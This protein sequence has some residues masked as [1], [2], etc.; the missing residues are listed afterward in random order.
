[1]ATN[2]DD[3]P[4]PVAKPTPLFVVLKPITYRGEV[5]ETTVDAL[6]SGARLTAGQIAAASKLSKPELVTWYKA[7][8]DHVTHPTLPPVLLP[9]EHLAE[10]ARALLIKRGVIAAA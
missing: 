4:K 6:V 8:S 7:N 3:K 9:F 1:M 10:S 2:I 5:N